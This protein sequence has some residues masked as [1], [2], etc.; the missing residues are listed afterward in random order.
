MII[1]N[2][3]DFISE[4]MKIMP[5]SN[6]EFDKVKLSKIDK[7]PTIYIKHWFN[8]SLCAGFHDAGNG[9]RYN[10]YKKTIKPSTQ[11]IYVEH[12]SHCYTMT[13]KSL[14]RLYNNTKYSIKFED[15]DSIEIRGGS[16]STKVRTSEA[17][18]FY[19]AISYVNILSK[20]QFHNI[21]F[22][23]V[24]LGIS[25]LALLVKQFFI[26]EIRF[27]DCMF[28][29]YSILDH[30]EIMNYSINKNIKFTSPNIRT[31]KKFEEY[32]W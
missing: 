19:K 22:D 27:V 11:T 23:S 16:L 31:R 10:D 4:K 32:N 28:N 25:I 14:D 9:D 8:S 5:I 12:P 24:E 13:I 3:K 17:E 21:I 20:I 6:D 15:G 26:E 29:D 30:D 18:N 2:S 7:N 1:L